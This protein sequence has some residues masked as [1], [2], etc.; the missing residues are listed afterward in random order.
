V[1]G[2]DSG[3]GNILSPVE[4]TI[5]NEYGL[6]TGQQVGLVQPVAQIV[7]LSKLWVTAFVPEN[8]IQDV[9]VGQGVDVRLPGHSDTF[10]GT[11][12]RIV[13]RAADLTGTTYPPLPTTDYANGNF[14]PV[15]QR[16]PVQISVDGSPG[17]P[18]QSATV[19]IHLRD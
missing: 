19:T 1:P 16:I 8:H 14:V 17:Y 15:T 9:H 10:H 3:G 11:V 2:P 18:G 4:G 5:V 6:V 12:N 7:R 13:D